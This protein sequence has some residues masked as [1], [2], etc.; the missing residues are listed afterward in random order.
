MRALAGLAALCGGCRAP[1]VTAAAQL[2]AAP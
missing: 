1:L 2:P